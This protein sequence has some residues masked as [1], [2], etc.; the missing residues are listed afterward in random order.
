MNIKIKSLFLL[1]AIAFLSAC[2]SQ[3]MGDVTSGTWEYTINKEAIEKESVLIDYE[4]IDDITDT[5]EGTYEFYDDGT[6]QIT[7]TDGDYIY[8]GDYRTSENSLIISYQTN[9]VMHVRGDLY[10]LEFQADSIKNK[11]VNGS[12]RVDSDS[13]WS[14]NEIYSGSF[15]MSKE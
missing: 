10:Q 13:I 4:E 3:T 9:G 2:G 8:R 1:S 11:A 6:V 7:P 14:G 15:S 12:I 5:F